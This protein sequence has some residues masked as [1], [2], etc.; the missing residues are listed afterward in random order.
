MM[1]RTIEVWLFG[2]A[3]NNAVIQFPHR[4]N[5]GVVI[6]FDT[7][8]QLVEDAEELRSMLSRRTKDEEL[9]EEAEALSKNLREILDSAAQEFEKHKQKGPE[10]T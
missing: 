1:K 5:P 7:L 4:Q 6:Q 3:I 8:S 10:S 2:E 9:Q